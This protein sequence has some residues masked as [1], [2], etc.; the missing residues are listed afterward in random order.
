MIEDS[1]RKTSEGE[2]NASRGPADPTDQADPGA[3]SAGDPT[4]VSGG[5]MGPVGASRFTGHVDVYGEYEAAF[6]DLRINEDW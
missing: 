5:G 2:A 3:R 4:P 6:G 1:E